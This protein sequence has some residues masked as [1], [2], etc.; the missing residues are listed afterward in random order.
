MLLLRLDG[1]HAPPA[2]PASGPTG[3]EPP[4]RSQPHPLAPTAIGG[5]RGAAERSTSGDA[6]YE[7]YDDEEMLALALQLSLQ[8]QQRGAG[9]P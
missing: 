3:G 5:G 1:L 7:Y 6:A 9:Q 8:E 2:M 4:S